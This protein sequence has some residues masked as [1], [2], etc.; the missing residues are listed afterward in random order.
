MRLLINMVFYSIRVGTFL[1]KYSPFSDDEVK[2]PIVDKD[3]NELEYVS[4]TRT[5]GYYINSQKE[6]VEK[7]F[8]LFNN[9]AVEKFERTKETDRYKE[10]EIKDRDD[11]VNPKQYIVECDNLLRDLKASGKALKFRISFGGKSI[12]YYAVICINENYNTLEMWISH[13]LKSNQY[14][15][16]MKNLNDKKQIEEMT[17]MIEGINKKAKIEELEI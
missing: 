3:K 1:I 13:G 10:V 4:G 14:S 6:K 16:Y 12:P 9:E 5:N 7:T 17:M 2:L 15:N 8:I 11:L